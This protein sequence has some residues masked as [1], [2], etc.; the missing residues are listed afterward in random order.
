MTAGARILA[1]V[2]DAF[3]AGGGI[4]QY[5]RDLLTALSG[6]PG[7]VAIDVLPRLG[8]AVAANLPP[9][10][11]QFE[12]IWHQIAYSL[13]ALDIALRSR[14]DIVFCGHLFMAPLAGFLARLFGARLVIQTHGVEVWPMPTPLQR[15]AVDGADLVL[16]VSRN[17]RARVIGWAAIA[18][19]RVVVLPNTVSDIYR[20]GEGSALRT[21]LGVDD[22][23]VLLSVSRLDAGQRYKG[24]ERVIQIIEPLRRR[25]H[26]VVYLI[27][28]SGGDSVRLKALARDS[29]V[30]EW[31]RFLGEIPYDMLP[32]LYRAADLYLM[33]SSG[34][35]FGIV[36]LEAMACGL[37]A[38]GLAAGGAPDALCEGVA[39][40]EPDLEDAVDRALQV[41]KPDPEALSSRVRARFGRPQFQA[42]A[43]LLFDRLV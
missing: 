2:T 30:A 23:I 15:A 39:V 14:P 8:S 31:V 16:C 3:G 29:G 20:P 18:P 26:D 6:W 24:Q 37:P 22:K 42:R 17:T 41:V 36:F 11:R 43:E 12:P 7:A 9:R 32:D 19:D 33:P 1:L 4:A 35:G 38:L 28:G 10:T 34:E 13:R 25:G 5:N 40:D 21:R 27:G